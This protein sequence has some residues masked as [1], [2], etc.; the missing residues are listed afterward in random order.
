[1]ADRAYGDNI[2]FE[3]A[4]DEQQR[5]YV[6]AQRVRVGYWSPVHAAHSFQEQARRVWL[7]AWR[8]VERRF[9]EGHTERWWATGLT[10]LG[11][12]PDRETRAICATTDRRTLPD[13]FTDI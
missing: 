6:L 2:A 11:Y 1:V 8:K 5:P 3:G 12:G 7:S 13:L 9:R 4:L 10:L